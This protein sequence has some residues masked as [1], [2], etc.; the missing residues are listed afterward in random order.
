[1]LISRVRCGGARQR[2]TLQVHA[3]YGSQWWKWCTTPM[4]GRRCNP[5]DFRPFVK[6]HARLRHVQDAMVATGALCFHGLG[7]GPGGIAWWHQAVPQRMHGIGWKTTPRRWT[8]CWPWHTRQGAVMWTWPHSGWKRCCPELPQLRGSHPDSRCCALGGAFWRASG[9]GL[10]QLL[11]CRCVA[12]HGQMKEPGPNDP[13]PCGCTMW[14]LVKM[15]TCQLPA[16][17][18]ACQPTGSA[19]VAGEGVAL[20]V[21]GTN[22]PV[23]AVTWHRSMRSDGSTRGQGWKPTPQVLLLTWL[24]WAMMARRGQQQQVE[25]M[26]EPNLPLASSSCEVAATDAIDVVTAA[27][28]REWRQV[29]QVQDDEDFAYAFASYDQAVLAGGDGLAAAWIEIRAAQEEKLMPV[30]AAVVAATRPG[31]PSAVPAFRP[32][33]KTKPRATSRRAG[34]R[35]RENTSFAPDQVT[36]RA[37]VLASELQSLGALKPQG[38]LTSRLEEEWAGSCRRLSQHL[39][40]QAEPITITHAVTTAKELK[41]FMSARGRGGFP[42]FVDLDSYLHDATATTAPC[43]ALKALKW[44]NRNGQ[45]G[46]DL[47]GLQ[48][49]TAR[50][51][52]EAKSRQAVVVAPP[53][54]PFLEEQIERLYGIGDPKWSALLAS[55]LM[56]SGCLRYRHLTRSAPR[57]LTKST[58][59]LSCTKGK[60]RRLRQGFNYCVPSHLGTG[61]DWSSPLLQ[62]IHRLP[63]DQQKHCGLCFD[64]DGNPWAI[65]EVT[66]TCREVFHGQIDEV[67]WLTTYSWRRWSST[68]AHTLK[69]SPTEGAALGDWQNRTDLPQ[70]ARMPLHYSG[71]RY[72]QS[73]RVKHLVQSAANHL[74]GFESWD[75]APEQAAAQAVKQ[76]R[77]AVDKAIQ[78]DKIVVWS[79]PITTDEA[80]ERFS[81]AA[82]LRDRAA[83]ARRASAHLP[84]AKSMPDSIQGKQLSSFLKS[85]ALLCGAF[86]L[87]RC[88]I[89]EGECSGRHQCAVTFKSGR[90]CGGQHPAS[91]CWNRRAAMVSA[92]SGRGTPG[93]E[94]G[95]A[96]ER[97]PRP[98]EPLEP[99]KAKRQKRRAAASAVHPGDEVVQLDEEQENTDRYFDYMAG[100]RHRH[101][102]APT[103]IYV[104]Q[105]GGT[106]WLGPLPTE[107]TKNKFPK[108]TLQVTCF[109]DLPSTKGGIIL[110]GVMQI[111]I[112]PSAKRDRVNQW[113]VQWPLIKNTLFSCESVLLHCLAGRHRAA[114]VGMLVRAVLA[115]E[116]LEDSEAHIKARREVDIPG[117]MRDRSIGAW[118]AEMKRTTQVTPG[119]P[120]VV[121]CIATAKSKLH[122]MTVGEIPLCSH[123]QSTDRAADRLVNP[124]KTHDFYEAAAWQRPTCEACV[125][126]APAGIQMLFRALWPGERRL[127]MNSVEKMDPGEEGFG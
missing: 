21:N 66:L 34:L 89:P 73:M 58:F 18:V 59:H 31:R 44:L 72:T 50:S 97:S 127:A 82:A 41:A 2:V 114:G 24:S 125:G 6:H 87:Q 116:S 103:A 90:V 49:P 1:M 78:Q 43:R 85:G 4:L 93:E 107:E 75:L 64:Q 108:V 33:P 3:S 9:T 124:L 84:A 92:P 117:L 57:R 77:I 113:R 105:A 27:R 110:P 109:N 99:P 46:W 94:A 10:I 30:A 62:A 106:L 29:N 101:D 38:W 81:L 51:K 86:Q 37:A 104:S 70:E 80:R 52:R 36:H 5:W 63:A 68:V 22:E 96:Q 28:I 61:W 88:N 40:T 11:G 54:M 71:A 118:V 45:L 25:C 60:Q 8:C 122:L 42:G 120:K 48:A 12:L 56:A 98:P 111:Y 74:Q 115:N 95:K 119:F 13:L 121:G 102:Q 76:G 20:P 7:H 23:N 100:G 15:D 35:L 53:M 47:Q 67:E 14:K 55:W 91:Q 69:L 39:V 123:K 83:K 26:E 32:L 126:R 65:R 79:L 19:G 17:S 112:A 16:I